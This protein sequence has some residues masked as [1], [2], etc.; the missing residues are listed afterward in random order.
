[1]AGQILDPG[2]LPPLNRRPGAEEYS[3]FAHNGEVENP[4]HLREQKPSL[5]PL[6]IHLID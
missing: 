3:R 1:V 4:C 2:A 6:A 5:Q